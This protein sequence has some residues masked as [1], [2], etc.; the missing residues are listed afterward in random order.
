VLARDT[1]FSA[2]E[3]QVAE[4]EE[5]TWIRQAQAGDREAFA[6]LVECYWMQI[7]RCL[8]SLSQN[9]HAAEDLTQEVFLKALAKLKSFKPGSHFRAWLFRIAHNSF[10]N[11]RRG[12]RIAAR[13]QPLSHGLTAR[14]P[15]PM[16][17]LATHETLALVEAA[18]DRLP[19]RYRMALLLRA[20]E[21]L[22]FLEIGQIL[23]VTTATARWHVFKAR[24]LLLQELGAILNET[25]T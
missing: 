17:T 20:R 3:T 10:L 16:T 7:F 25:I 5:Q 1:T 6:S 23:S 13:P 15:D 4:P 12:P 14:Q 19:V 22:P 18:V 11:S 24:H 8:Y 2:T 21:Q 9:T